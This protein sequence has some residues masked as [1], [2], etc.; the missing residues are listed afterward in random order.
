MSDDSSS[1]VD[2]VGLLSRD[3]GTSSLQFSD[4]DLDILDVPGVATMARFISEFE[5]ILKLRV[6]T[7]TGCYKK[8]GKEYQPCLPL[9]FNKI[10]IFKT[11][12]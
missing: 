2:N 7:H 11:N 10:T 12:Y 5:R 3:R 9:N 6:A 1:S 8:I 4:S